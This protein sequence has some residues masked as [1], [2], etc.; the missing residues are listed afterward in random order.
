MFQ[1]STHRLKPEPWH[2]A[3]R[4]V[5]WR[6]LPRKALAVLALPACL[7]GAS[8]PLMA[9]PP[10]APPAAQAAASSAKASTAA[11]DTLTICDS[12]RP[13]DPQDED[14]YEF[15]AAVGSL[16]L[17][18]R[19]QLPGKVR[20]LMRRDADALCQQERNE[21]G[22]RASTSIKVGCVFVSEQACTIVTPRPASHAELGNA[23][24]NCQP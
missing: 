24:R 23:V 20:W 4:R 17:S 11:V 5:A 22:E 16:G 1:T 3:A 8:G 12:Q 15:G 19:Q 14:C 7:L 9:G 21:F 18:W 6:F 2:R 13:A 10:V